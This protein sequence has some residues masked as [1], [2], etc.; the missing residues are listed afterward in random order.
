MSESEE[1]Y[2]VTIAMLNENGVSDPVPLSQ[3][4]GKLQ[5]QP[6]SANQMVR[7]LERAG[8]LDYT[9]YKGVALTAKGWQQASQI[10][11]HRRLWEVFLVERLHI[12][13]TE[14]DELACRLEHILPSDAAE[15][16]AEYLGKPIVSPA[17]KPIPEPQSEGRLESGKLLSQ[18][19]VGERGRVTRVQA[20]SATRRF[21]AAEG[22]YPKTQIT[23]TAIGSEG[24]RLVST[25]E[26]HTINLAAELSNLI[27][28]DKIGPDD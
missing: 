23:I 2:L 6:V 25:G 21:M 12:S 22:L 4:A 1:M 26:G 24:S 5:V 16:L 17:G 9:P 3:V 20:D 14:A 19:Q 15:H 11:R 18:L 28:V 27:H 7:K 13:P 8:L 10:L